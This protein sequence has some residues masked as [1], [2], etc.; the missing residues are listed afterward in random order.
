MCWNMLFFLVV[1]QRSVAR[2]VHVSRQLVYC[3]STGTRQNLNQ[4]K[5]SEDQSIGI[6]KCYLALFPL[7]MHTAHFQDPP[8]VFRQS[9]LPVFSVYLP[10]ERFFEPPPPIF[11]LRRPSSPCNSHSLLPPSISFTSACHFSPPPLNSHPYHPFLWTEERECGQENVSVGGN[12]ECAQKI[13]EV[14]C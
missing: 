9:P 4:Q 6:N 8:P 1:A 5:K 7:T 14:H 11:S 2:Q 10:F 12:F 13:L 3:K